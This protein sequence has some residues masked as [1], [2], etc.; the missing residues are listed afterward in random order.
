MNFRASVHLKPEGR[1]VP[2]EQ[3]DTQ[4]QK[5]SFEGEEIK[6]NGQDRRVRGIHHSVHPAIREGMG[7]MAASHRHL[8]KS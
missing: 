1:L 2:V 7:E 6:P 8:L 3:P 5:V 4:T